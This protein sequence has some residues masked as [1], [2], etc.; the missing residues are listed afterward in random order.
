[1]IA[2]FEFL[3]KRIFRH[4]HWIDLTPK[5]LVGFGKCMDDVGKRCLAYDE[6]IYVAAN[7][8]LPLRDRTKNE[9]HIHLGGQWRKRF[10]QHVRE[11]H[12]LSENAG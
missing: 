8:F 4:H 5:L 9:C 7:T 10:A 12:R 6:N 3:P 2:L 1:M 11:P